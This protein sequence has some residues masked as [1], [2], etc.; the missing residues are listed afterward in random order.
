VLSVRDGGFPHYHL[1]TDTPEHVDLGSVDAC[2]RLAGR[3][4][5]AWS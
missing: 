3:V 5:L 2:A 1:P 4:A